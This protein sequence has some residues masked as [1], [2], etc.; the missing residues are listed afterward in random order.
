M[1]TD[2]NIATLTRLTKGRYKIDKT[3]FEVLIKE[4]QATSCD[5]LLDKVFPAKTVRKRVAAQ[6]KPQWLEDMLKA[7][8]KLS[9]SAAEATARLFEIAEQE[10]FELTKA[11]QKSFP[12]AS[13]QI[14]GQLG[15]QRTRDLFVNWV[16][17][18]A[19]THKMA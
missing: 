9:W 16:S 4:V 18:F 17:D 13:E 3:T 19:E 15:E 1:I 5:E 12:K 6:P 14:A 2:E 10:G 11:K 7:R 8:K